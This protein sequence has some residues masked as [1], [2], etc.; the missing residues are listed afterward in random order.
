[1]HSD[2]HDVLLYLPSRSIVIHA[3]GTLGTLKLS[4]HTVGFWQKP[5]GN[6]YICVH[7]LHSFAS[8]LVRN[9]IV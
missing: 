1:M 7:D 4:Q 8:V 2:D 6:P 9:R 5:V 3:L